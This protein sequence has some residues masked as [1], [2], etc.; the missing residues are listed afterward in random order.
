MN[1]LLPIETINREIDFKLTLAGLLVNG[2]NTIYIGQHNFINLLL[3]KFQNGIYVG[4]NVFYD[5]ASKEKGDIYRKFKK[6]GFNIIYLHEEGA[7][8]LGMEDQWRRTLSSQ[9]NTEFFDSSDVIC[10]WGEFQKKHDLSRTK[11]AEVVVTGHPRFDLY[12]DNWTKY[13]D[14]QV[15]QIKSIHKEYILINGNYGAYN[16]GLGVN[17]VFSSKWNYNVD[18]IE[19][20]KK[21][22]SFFTY[23]GMQCMAM[24][25]LTH[26]LA[27]LYPHKNFIFRPHP[28]ENHEFYKIVFKGVKNIH[29]NHDGPVTPWILGADAI[30]HDGCTTALE[31]QMCNKMVINF[32]P[33]FN[34]KAD[35]WLPN[36]MGF[37]VSA[38]DE[39]KKLLDKKDEYRFDIDKSPDKELISDVFFNFKNDSFQKLLEVIEK[40][41]EDSDKK[42]YLSPSDTY[43]QTQ[44]L[45]QKVKAELSKIKNGKSKKAYEY[46]SRKFYGFDKTYIEEKIKV[47]EDMLS[48]KITFKYHN[49]YLIEIR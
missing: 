49:P 21:R 2:E 6:K 1:I 46:H 26:H 30:I 48:K 19:N 38:I 9:Y 36:Q 31:A 34:S 32:K 7:V 4:K 27:I 33:F 28:S 11:K 16:H 5:F 47:L 15:N 12:K 14:K 10:A 3:E 43:I 42:E 45:K 13:F 44:Y 40:K 20:R 18:D 25:D 8:F 35:I 22:V 17:Y 24:I 39:V 29:V 41:I 23:S 37:R